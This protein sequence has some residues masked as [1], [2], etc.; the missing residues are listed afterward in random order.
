MGIGNC[1][2]PNPQIL[3]PFYKMETTPAPL[4][5]YDPDNMMAKCYVVW[6]EAKIIFMIKDKEYDKTMLGICGYSGRVFKVASTES[7]TTLIVHDIFINDH[8][9]EG[10]CEEGKRCLDFNCPKNRTTWESFRKAHSIRSRKPPVAFGQPIWFNIDNDGE[11]ISYKEFVLKY[12][13]GVHL[14]TEDFEIQDIETS[15]SNVH[16]KNRV[17]LKPSLRFDI[18]KRDNYRC[19][20][21]GRTVQE[22]I[23]LEV[24]HKHPVAKGGTNELLNLW[25]LCQECN[26]GKGTKTI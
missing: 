13:K 4:F 19:Q 2:N 3:Q 16:N 9:Q 5:E 1:Y 26:I 18:F 7:L 6:V 23:R 12:P 22:G 10:G 17:T 15:K 20:I 21:C 11:L 8:T 14:T 24:D 25:I